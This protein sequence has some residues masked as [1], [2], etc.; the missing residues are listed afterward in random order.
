MKRAL[1]S[2]LSAGALALAALPAAADQIDTAPKVSEVV[3]T[4]TRIPT[5]EDKVANA[6]TVITKQ[7]I[8]E[9]QLEDLP[10]A[11]AT[12]PG[13]NVVRSGGPGQVTSTFVRGTNSNH[14]LVLIDGIDVSDPSIPSGFDFG[15]TLLGDVSRIEVLRGPGSSL[16][17]SQALG[18]VINIITTAPG[19]PAAASAS[20]EGGS[21]GT[22]N[23]RLAANGEAGRLGYA[24]DLEHYRADDTPVTPPELLPPGQKAIGDAYDNL[25]GSGRFSV[26]VSDDAKLDLSLRYTRA[27]LRFTGDNENLFPSVPSVEQSVQDRR[28]LFTRADLRRS[29]FGGRLTSVLGVDYTQYR[30]REQDPDT[31]FGAPAANISDGARLGAD[32]QGDLALSPDSNMV[33]G[34]GDK[35]DRLQNAGFPAHDNDG[36]GFAELQTTPL[37]NLT[38]AA[39]A[40]LDDYQREGDAPT[41]HVGATYTVA[42]TGTKVS[43]TAGTA[44]AAPTLSDLFVSFPAF[45]FFANPNLKPERSFGYDLGVEQP[46]G[47]DRYRVGVTWYHND[48]RDLIEATFDPVTFTSSLANVDRA[49]TYGVESFVSAKVTDRFDLRADYTWTV[50]KNT[51]TGLELLRRP[52]HKV[53]GTATWRPTERLTLSATALYVGS[54]VDANRSFS[55]ARLN[56]PSF[57]TLNVAAQYRVNDRTVLFGRVD[58]LF[59][60]TYQD[61]VGFLQPGIGAFVGVKLT[62][63][64][65]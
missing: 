62:F 4:A 40:R 14:V 18:G 10:A 11:L 55:I 29:L 41:W 7:D 1:F 16:Y 52:K 2:S 60:R 61:P 58:N 28:E 44:F 56:A 49:T 22:F 3:V 50:A 9:R 45:D 25:T 8:T 26:A 31:G 42:S 53:S 13:V 30:T 51:D 33:L 35:D 15:Q 24:L 37:A 48:I 5:P 46:F 27:I 21:F 32:W 65:A 6:I 47:G 20:L 39:S 17:G 59:D 64:G 54:W 36:W 23:Q 43:A 63:D 12:V 38:L 19:G 34:L 57:A